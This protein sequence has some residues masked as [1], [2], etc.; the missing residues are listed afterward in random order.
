MHKQNNNSF[1]WIQSRLQDHSPPQISKL[2]QDCLKSL[3]FQEM[4][5]RFHDIEHATEGTC[6]WLLRHQKYRAWTD[7]HHGMLCIKGKPGSGK[8]TLLHYAIADAI[9]TS[10]IPN[11]SLIQQNESLVESSDAARAQPEPNVVTLSF[12]FHDRGT[13]LQKTPLGLFRSLLHQLLRHIPDTMPEDLLTTFQDRMKNMGEVGEKWV[14]KWREVRHFYE[15]SLQKALESHQVFL[16]IDALDEYG[17]IDANELIKSF[18]SWIQACPPQAQLHICFTCRHFPLLD[19]PQEL[20]EIRLEEENKD[21]ISTYVQ[22]KLSAWSNK[23]NLA[24]IWMDITD[25]AS[26]VFLWAF[27]IVPDVLYLES[28]GENWKKI[29]RQ[30]ENTPQ[31]LTELYRCLLKKVETDPNAFRLIKWI[32]FSMEPLTLNELRWAMI[33]DP[34]YSDQP[35]SLRRY[36]DT[37]DFATDCEMM[38]KKLNALSCGLAE[39]IPSSRVVQFI[40]QSV[41]D[42]FV[43]EGLEILLKS[44]NP[45][46]IESNEADLESTVHY[47]LCRTCIRYLSTEEIIQSELPFYQLKRTFPLLRYATVHWI[48]HVQQS[49]PQ[50][51][52]LQYFSWPSERI[53]Q[54]WSKFRVSENTGR[55]RRPRV[56]TSLLHVASQYQLMGLVK[57]I[58]QSKE[59]LSV[60]ID[61][62]DNMRTTPLWWAALTGYEAVVRLLVDNGAQ[63]NP[64]GGVGE[65][66]LCVASMR[67]NEKIVQILLEKGADVNAGEN[68]EALIIASGHGHEQ[69]VRMLVEKGADMKARTKLPHNFS[70]LEIASGN[71]HVQ[72]VRILLRQ[73]ADMKL[74]R[75][76]PRN[77]NALEMASWSGHEQIVRI[78]LE[79]GAD[80]N[81]WNIRDDTGALELASKEGHKKIVQILLEYDAKREKAQS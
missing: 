74:K 68:S 4:E 47:Q 29:K 38:E 11:G 9:V 56:K 75:S 80:V 35:A 28:R 66:P 39:A 34:E 24:T 41:K 43:R 37:E 73:G 44:Q 27:L 54:L 6:T 18:N 20:V 26:G 52:L 79:Q 36:E 48:A 49:F 62:R 33:V 42:F 7:D 69:I 5:D 45:A 46:G 72:T 31:D 23:E 10:K 61:A 12:F 53:V 64:K 30:I 22:A 59:L 13:D 58:M 77:F 2:S 76:R 71:C 67:G 57:E 8:S 78:L 51:D 14:W 60:K 40:H 81:N 25:R 70:A 21:D 55:L 65:N 19:L 3:A 32:C 17:E 63:V 1:S 15:E 16:F 50:T